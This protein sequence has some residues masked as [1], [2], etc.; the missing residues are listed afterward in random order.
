VCGVQPI[1]DGGVELNDLVKVLGNFW[2][3]I[4]VLLGF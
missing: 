2:C 4:S 3:M 1:F